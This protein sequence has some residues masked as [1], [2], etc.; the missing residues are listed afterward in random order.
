MTSVGVHED[1]AR[2]RS[3]RDEN[4]SNRRVFLRSYPLY[5]EDDDEEEEEEEEQDESKEKKVE[6]VRGKAVRVKKMFVALVHW[7]GGKVLV[8]R[9]LKHKVGVYLIACNSFSIKPSTALI[10]G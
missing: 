6:R 5:W 1:G 2:V 10:S 8:F 4:Y 3:F 9:K 7:G